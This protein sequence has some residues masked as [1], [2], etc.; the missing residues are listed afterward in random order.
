VDDT[1]DEEDDG[2][3]LNE[4]KNYDAK[5]SD[6]YKFIANSKAIQPICITEDVDFEKMS[7]VERGLWWLGTTIKVCSILDNSI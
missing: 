3:L 6:Y 5:Y 4:N 7:L 2:V 1:T